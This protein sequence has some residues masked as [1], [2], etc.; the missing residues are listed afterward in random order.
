MPDFDATDNKESMPADF[1]TH[2]SILHFD[3][4]REQ[5][6]IPESGRITNIESIP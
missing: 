1:I 2:D 5:E 6:V 4:L 3:D